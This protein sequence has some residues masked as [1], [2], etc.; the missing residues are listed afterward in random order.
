MSPLARFP[1]TPA[2]IDAVV[3]AF[4]AA[5]RS[6]PTLA[7]IF[8]SHIADWPAH[9]MKIAL[10]W[11]NAILLEG[12]YDGNP[13]ATHKAAG[14]VHPGMFEPWLALFDQ[15]LSRELP[16]EIAKAWSA[17]AH[18]IGRGLRYGL[19]DSAKTASGIPLLR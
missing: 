19:V 4:Y 11:R 18:R 2:Q 16:S 8:A 14:N 5:V 12:G 10:F 15:T 3:A 6:H 7:P 1:I 17:L 13:M 9:E